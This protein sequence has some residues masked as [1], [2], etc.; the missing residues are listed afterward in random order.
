MEIAGSGAPSPVECSGT[1]PS[2][3]GLSSDP[4]TNLQMG[5]YDSASRVWD[6]KLESGLCLVSGTLVK[7]AREREKERE[8]E[9]LNV[10]KSGELAIHPFCLRGFVKNRALCS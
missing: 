4:S 8:R 1:C 5:N 3:P 10:S 6:K 7:L 9:C 2:H